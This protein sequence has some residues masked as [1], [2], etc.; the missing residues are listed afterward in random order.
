MRQANR[1]IKRAM[2]QA[3]WAAAHTRNTY[4]AAF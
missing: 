2:C 1:S 4:P 3:A